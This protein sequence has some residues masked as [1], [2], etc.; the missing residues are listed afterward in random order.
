MFVLLSILLEAIDLYL[1]R[2]LELKKV[3]LNLT[4]NLN[5]TK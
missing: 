1:N 3:A 2:A 4:L 5:L